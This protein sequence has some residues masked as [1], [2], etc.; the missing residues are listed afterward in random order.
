MYSVL[1]IIFS[2]ILPLFWLFPVYFWRTGSVNLAP[3]TVSVQNYNFFRYSGIH[4]CV[5]IEVN[6]YF[7][8][9]LLHPN[10]LPQHQLLNIFFPDSFDIYPVLYQMLT[11]IRSISGLALGTGDLFVY[12]CPRAIPFDLQLLCHIFLISDNANLP[13]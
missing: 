7:D 3:V 9:F 6:I 4:S 1:K 5:W 12:F 2:Y 10:Y 8:F 11:Y 13:C